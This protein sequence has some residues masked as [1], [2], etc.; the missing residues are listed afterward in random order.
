MQAETRYS[1]IE[2]PD[3]S[4]CMAKWALELGEFD[5]SFQPRIAIKSQVL[6]DFF[7]ELTQLLGAQMVNKEKCEV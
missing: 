1:V 2:K 4:V 6:V 5:V 7:A 3:L